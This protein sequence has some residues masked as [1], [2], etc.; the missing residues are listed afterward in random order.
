MTTLITGARGKIGQ[1]VIARLHDDGLPVRA[2][3]ADPSAL[4]VPAGVDTA[5]LRL[6]APE[7]F[8]A[9]LKGVTQVLLYAE[10]AAIDAFIATAQA[11][12]VEHI[13]LI[14]SSSVLDA[15]ATDDSIGGH[16]LA[17]ENALAASDLTTTVLRPGAFASNTFGW[18]Y[19]ISHDLPIQLAY[20]D[21]GI[22][23]I[24]TADIADIAIAALTGATAVRGRTFNLTGP[25]ALTFREQLAIVSDVLG[26]D[27]PLVHITHAEQLA[28]MSQH[29]PA[30]MADGLLDF[31]AAATAH[32]ETVGDTAESVLGTTA[33]SFEQWV[34][35]H[36]AA[37]SRS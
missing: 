7:T 37:F 17:V 21:A 2:A 23:P 10:P 31:W 25:Q 9:A 15:D 27:I 36:A 26:R 4:T 11:A 16:H 30:D 14:S 29:M 13:V 22:T 28:Q 18:A 8:D 6:D 5:E 33:R 1:A 34:R 12:G 20:P 35:E 3:S 32:P 24:H 19:F